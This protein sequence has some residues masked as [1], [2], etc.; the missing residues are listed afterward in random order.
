MHNEAEKLH[1]I[2]DVI[3]TNDAS[4]L[5]QVASLFAVGNKQPIVPVSLT[6]FFGIWTADEANEISSVIEAACE[7]IHPSD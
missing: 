1:I 2:E 6:E 7:N 4:L 5:S 3:N